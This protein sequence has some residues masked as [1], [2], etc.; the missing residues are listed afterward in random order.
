MEVHPMTPELEDMKNKKFHTLKQHE[1]KLVMD[2]VI[3]NHSQVMR[4][5]ELAFLSPDFHITPMRGLGAL[6][7]LMCISSSYTAGLQ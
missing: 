4:T 3:L 6:T 5:F 2:L 1:G 7:D